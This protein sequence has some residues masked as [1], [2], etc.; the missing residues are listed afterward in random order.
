MV[1]SNDK[2][3]L[4]SVVR[5]TR[6][7]RSSEELS[8]ASTSLAESIAYLAEQFEWRRIAGFVPTASEPPLARG[9]NDLVGKGISVIVPVSSEGGLLDWVELTSE[10]IWTTTPDSMGMPVPSVGE[11]A[12]PDRLDAVL[13]PAAAVD[14]HGNR[15]GWGK[16]YYDRFLDSVGGD[17]LIIAVVFDSDVVED[18]PREPHDAPVHLILTESGTTF[19]Q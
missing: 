11:Q 9:L 19:A 2:A 13:I 18:V 10:S 7:A 8:V 17:P 3:E 14:R 6:A 4:R 16:G 12:L 15:L 5:L 1:A